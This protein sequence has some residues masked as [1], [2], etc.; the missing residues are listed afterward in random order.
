[1][2]KEQFIKFNCETEDNINKLLDSFV[3]QDWE[4]QW[5]Y[6]NDLIIKNR[7]SVNNFII[8]FKLLRSAKIKVKI[9]KYAFM[10]YFCKEFNKGF[11][12]AQILANF[13]NLIDIKKI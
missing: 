3:Y 9:D 8:L 11:N 6:F 7:A 1:M 2:T 10:S 4:F 13:I 12:E 5:S